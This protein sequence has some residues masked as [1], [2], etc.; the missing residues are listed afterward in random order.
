MPSDSAPGN[1]V[2]L[3]IAVV[4]AAVAI[5][6]AAVVMGIAMADHMGGGHMRGSAPADTAVVLEGPEVSID[7]RDFRYHP[8]NVSIPAG[9]TVTWTNGDRA[10]H[11]A[12]DREGEWRTELLQQDESD[13]VTFETPGTYEY[14]CSVHPNMRAILTVR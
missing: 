13:S 7:I 11:D 12:V 10:P 6:G 8:S 1:N 5:L 3:A 14:Y 9:T 2:T 4:V